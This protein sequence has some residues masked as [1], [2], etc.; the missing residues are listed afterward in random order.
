MSSVRLSHRQCRRTPRPFLTILSVTRSRCSSGSLTLPNCSSICS[1]TSFIRRFVVPSDLRQVIIWPVR[2]DGHPRAVEARATQIRR[3]GARQ[4]AVRCPC[5]RSWGH[6]GGDECE[7]A[8]LGGM[9]VTTPGHRSV[10]LTS[11]RHTSWASTTATVLLSVNQFLVVVHIE[12]MGTT[13]RAVSK[14]KGL[15]RDHPTT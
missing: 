4:P 14:C 2:V 7:A 13:E 12:D 6:E 9:Q 15:C 10:L 8:C 3:I 1:L 11:V 5:T